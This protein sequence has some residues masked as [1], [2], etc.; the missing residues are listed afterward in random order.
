[1]V[2]ALLFF[3]TADASAEQV[4]VA[5]Q[6]NVRVVKVKTS[7]K[8]TA[9]G[10]CYK[11]KRPLEFSYNVTVRP[12]H[13][14]FYINRAF[15]GCDQVTLSSPSAFSVKGAEYSGELSIIKTAAGK[16]H[17][18]NVI[19][20]EEYV[21]GVIEKEMSPSW[22]L[23]ALKAQ[24]VASR[25]YAL[26]QVLQSIGKPYDL[27]S[28]TAS[29]VYRGAAKSARAKEAVYATRGQVALYQGEVAQTFFH[30]IAGGKTADISTV[31][32]GEPKAYLI[33]RPALF[34][35]RSP[36]FR[37]KV[38]F[39]EKTLR[40]K[41]RKE[42]Y[43]IGVIRSIKLNPHAASKRVHIVTIRHGASNENLHLKAQ[44]FRRIVG[45]TKLRSTRFNVSR[46]SNGKLFA[47]WGAGYG[48]GVG[49]SQWSARGM[50]ERGDK[51]K[52]I[53]THFYPG[54]KIAQAKSA[55]SVALIFHSR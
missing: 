12:S 17:V 14:G 39:S 33:S 46:R 9:T 51:Y 4:R 55:R 25:S 48:H 35:S 23:E 47:F 53:I 16:A 31:W 3:V 20:I 7:G 32:S 6:K 40:T 30:A 44:T 52:N 19:D 10:S 11:G 42:G 18:I 38:S 37:W 1:M 27:E 13:L 2:V 43:D 24:A 36:Y 41:L 29:Q 34:E 21:A 15:V 28:T 45:Y 50:A 22:P 26:Y 49:M 54:V 5:I 8:I